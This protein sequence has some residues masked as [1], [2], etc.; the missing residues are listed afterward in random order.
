MNRNKFIANPP[1]VTP[2]P[3][4]L[5]KVNGVFL[6]DEDLMSMAS[7]ERIVVHKNT[8]VEYMIQQFNVSDSVMAPRLYDI[9]FTAIN[10]PNTHI[11]YSGES[12]SRIFADFDITERTL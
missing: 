1:P 11:K 10:I 6:N 9:D 12:L 3:P 5:I 4:P 8:G 2:P 7:L